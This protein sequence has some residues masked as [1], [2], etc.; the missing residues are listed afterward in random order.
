MSTCFLWV[1]EGRYTDPCHSWRF[2]CR[3]WNHGV[4]PILFSK[5]KKSQKILTMQPAFS[6]LKCYHCF[7][8][9]S[10]KCPEK[11]FRGLWDVI[12]IPG[13]PSKFPFL[14]YHIPFGHEA[15]QGFAQM[16]YK[17]LPHF[18]E[19]G[20]S[21]RKTGAFISVGDN[22]SYWQHILPLPEDLMS[23]VFF[24]KVNLG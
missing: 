23:S 10:M 5:N 15:S 17:T 6:S 11:G 3:A 24:Q 13:K 4:S 19:S 7:L 20:S 16:R 18:L 2:H 21:S 8:T 9:N 14:C 1:G 22:T 12:R